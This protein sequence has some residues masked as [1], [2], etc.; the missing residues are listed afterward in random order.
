M[1]EKLGSLGKSLARSKS[2][3]QSKEKCGHNAEVWKAR[4]EDE[5][6]SQR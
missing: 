3:T 6:M 1:V 4:S 5:N 2:V